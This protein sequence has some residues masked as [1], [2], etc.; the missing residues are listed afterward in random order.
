MNKIILDLTDCKSLLQLH[1]TIKEAFCFPDYYGENLDALWD[2]MRGF[3][4]ADTM[5]YIKGVN[6][7]PKSFNE[8]IK[9]IFEIFED[10]KEEVQNVTFEIIS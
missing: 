1:K 6:T 2:C 10:V 4:S 9:K 3:C 8:Y 7:L 5:V